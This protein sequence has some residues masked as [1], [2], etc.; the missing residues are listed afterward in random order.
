VRNEEKIPLK[1]HLV[2]GY[3]SNKL[4]DEDGP[5]IPCGSSKLDLPLACRKFCPLENIRLQCIENV[6]I[7]E[8]TTA[9]CEEHAL[10][11]V[12]SG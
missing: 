9:L 6:R 7:A 4:G 5:S 12:R 1:G 3:W 8:G 11:G 2:Q 10:A